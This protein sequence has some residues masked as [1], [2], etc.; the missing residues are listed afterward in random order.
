[1]PPPNS[2]DPKNPVQKTPTR[3]PA[4]RPSPSKTPSVNGV[5]SGLGRTPSVRGGLARP[6]RGGLNRNSQQTSY[7]STNSA[8]DP[9]DEEARAEHASLLDELRSRVQKAETASEEYQRQLNLLQARLDESQQSHGQLE[10]QLHE[11]K[12]RVEE[13]ET[14]KIQASRQKR[15]LEKI[16]EEERTAILKDRDEQKAKEEGLQTSLRR[17]K[18]G[19]AQK[20]Q[21]LA[22]ERE[23]ASSRNVPEASAE[24]GQFAPPSSVQRSASSDNSK[25]VEQ[26]DRAIKSL[27]LELADAQIKIMEIDSDGKYHDLEKKLLETQITNARLMEDNESFQLLLNEKTLNGDFSKTELMKTSSGLGSLAEELGTEDI[28]TA[29]GTEG[30]SEDRRR[31]E[32][33]LKSLR[34][35]NKALALYIE[36]IIG[37]LLSHSEFENILDKNPDLM[38]GAPK[39]ARANTD[40]EL[41]PPPPEKD[42]PSEGAGSFLQRAKSVI[43]GPAKPRPRPMSQMPAPSAV[44][45][46][47]NL[48]P[49]PTEDPST[50]PSIPIG[51]SQSV[52]MRGGSHAHKRSQSDMPGAAPIVNQMYRGPPSTGSPALGGPLMSPGV[53]PG[54]SSA[55]RTSFFSPPATTAPSSNLTNPSATPRAPSGSRGSISHDGNPGSDSG[56]TFSDRSGGGIDSPP[57]TSVNN[58]NFTPAIMTQNRLRPLRL[59]Q[60]NPESKKKEDDA[61]AAARKK[62]N[63]GSWMPTWMAQRGPSGGEGQM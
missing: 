57:R 14:G 50:A 47:A 20:E 18:D 55:G 23:A 7:L 15:D 3:T 51:R 37:R 43:A 24:G 56:S 54:I 4:T 41:P 36:N 42:T 53:S 44:I 63:R 59:V 29:E 27:R 8:E 52:S 17:L 2:N 28:E 25:L 5:G 40:K 32:V 9:G 16:F 38:S 21:E 58:N 19:L 30:K 60:E 26:K 12:E 13:L 61:A 34:D 11:K 39:T 31:L 22:E 49:G 46:A 6:A 45:P 48:S 62:A 33:E 10:D 35:Q 1:M